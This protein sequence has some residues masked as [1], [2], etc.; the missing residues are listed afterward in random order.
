MNIQ[1][2]PSVDVF[3]FWKATLKC[4]KNAIYCDFYTRSN[5]S[6]YA[7]VVFFFLLT[8]VERRLNSLKSS[9][10]IKRSSEFS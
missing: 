8:I 7:N 2:S 5:A 4:L 9:S 1:E 10:S 3:E 6:L